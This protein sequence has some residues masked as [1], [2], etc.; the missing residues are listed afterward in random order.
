MTADRHP[1]EMP[2]SESE[3]TSLTRDLD[4]SH[5][6]TMPLMFARARDLSEQL[7]HGSPQDPVTTSARR[8][9]LMGAGGAFITLALAACGNNPTSFTATAPDP[10]TPPHS[11]PD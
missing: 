10:P 8:A 3:L 6:E 11:P 5:R 2:I 4:E 7:T 1:W 9:F